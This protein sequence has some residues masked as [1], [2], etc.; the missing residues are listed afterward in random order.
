MFF[1]KEIPAVGVSLGVDRLFS[2]IETTKILPTKISTSRVLVTI[3]DESTKIQSL[4][5]ADKLRKL[6][7]NTEIYLGKG[8]LS[9]QL[10]YADKK[11]IPL[12]II[13]GP[14]EIKEGQITIKDLRIKTQKRMRRDDLASVLKMVR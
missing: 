10:K 7:I 4:K 8:D 9:E 2:A 5:I 1:G 14:D 13:I 11:G 12:T 3:F 6:R